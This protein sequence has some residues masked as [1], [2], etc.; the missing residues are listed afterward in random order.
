VSAGYSGT[1]LWKKLGAK[2]GGEIAVVNFP[3]DAE[4]IRE[5]IEAG[6]NIRRGLKASEMLGILFCSNMAV[7]QKQLPA[8]SKKLHAD[9]TLWIS[10]PKKTSKFFQDLTEDGVRAVAL[11]MGLVDVKVCAMNADW[12]GLKLMVR[13]ELRAGWNN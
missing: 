3:K 2:E 11:P 10:W 9:G 7:L 13:K 4:E 1:P 8:A 12:S 5:Q 6:A